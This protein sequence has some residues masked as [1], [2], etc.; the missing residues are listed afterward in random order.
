M[1]VYKN[2][3]K[4]VIEEDY[5]CNHNPR[6]DECLGTMVFFHKRYT[7]GDKHDFE[8]P[9]E[10]DDWLEANKEKLALVLPVYMYEHGGVAFS[11]S[12]FSCP[13]DSG[14]LGYMYTTHKKVK[15]H[16]GNEKVSEKN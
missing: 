11:T 2:G 16:F 15:E 9:S 4:L 7:L 3:F 12:S 5:E 8:D 10:L 13:W 14:Q 6:Q 1:E